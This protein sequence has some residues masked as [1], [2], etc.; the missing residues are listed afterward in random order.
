LRNLRRTAQLLVLSGFAAAACATYVAPEAGEPVPDDSGG[1]AAEPHG[2]GSG[3]SEGGSS[4]SAGTQ[5]TAGTDG[6]P[7]L[8]GTGGTHSTSGGVAGAGNGGKAGSGS[9]NGGGG[10]GG[11]ASGGAASGGTAGGGKGGAGG[12]GGAAGIG[13]G[14]NGGGGGDAGGSAGMPNGGTGGGG[15]VNL[16]TNSGFETNATGWSVFGGGATI[17]TSTAEAKSGTHSLLVTGRTQTY[18]GPQY[19]LL[20]VVTSGTSYSL[21]VWGRL[22][23]TNPTGS[24]IATMR[25]T[26]TGGTN[27]GD[28]FSQWVSATAASASSWTELKGVKAFPTCGGGGSLTAAWL[29]IESPT[30]TLSYYIDEVVLTSP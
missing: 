16:I 3:N 8:G 26:C 4:E 1:E 9:A 7:D 17:A 22:A 19:N 20:N 12:G 21:S 11:A 25:Y 13:G 30:A 24:L 14:A 10:R 6:S 29:Y 5:S 15:A 28:N 18:Q 2:G 23:D 27:A